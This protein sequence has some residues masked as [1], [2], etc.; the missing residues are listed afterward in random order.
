MKDNQAGC[1][2]PVLAIITGNVPIVTLW[3][4][5]SGLIVIG[6]IVFVDQNCCGCRLRMLSGVTGQSARSTKVL[7]NSNV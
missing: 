2:S 7:S 5:V 4:P 3:Q 1:G 6:L